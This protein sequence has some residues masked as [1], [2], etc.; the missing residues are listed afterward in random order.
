MKYYVADPEL[1][2]MYR[3][4]DDDA[5]FDLCTATDIN[6]TDTTWQLVPTKLHLAIPKGY[7]GFIKPRSGLSVKFN[8][9]THAGVIDASYRGEVGILISVNKPPVT[10]HKG[11]RIAQLCLL[12]LYDGPA[13]QVSSLE[14]LE[15]TDR[16]AGG[17]G[18]TGGF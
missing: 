14:E 15:E 18:S 8:T 17:F 1:K 3:A 9:D 5:G 10:F 2:Q 16:G 6:L 12:K 13:E 7:V 4:H 11:D